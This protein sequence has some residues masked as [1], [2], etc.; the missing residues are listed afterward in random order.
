MQRR[1]T[2]KD[3]SQKVGINETAE[4]DERERAFVGEEKGWLQTGRQKEG[5]N[6]TKEEGEQSRS[7]SNQIVPKAGEYVICVELPLNA[8]KITSVQTVDKRNLLRRP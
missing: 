2:S 6:A 7:H 4:A 5:K 3:D 1:M 8:K